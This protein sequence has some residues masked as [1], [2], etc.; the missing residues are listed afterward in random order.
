MC[1]SICSKLIWGDKMKERKINTWPLITILL[2]L[3]LLIIDIFIIFIID[4]NIFPYSNKIAMLD[5]LLTTSLLII[6]PNIYLVFFNIKKKIF[7][8]IYFAII[9]AWVEYSFSLMA[10][11]FIIPL[12]IEL[13]Y[14]ITLNSSEK[15]T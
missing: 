9:F 2:S 7:F 6:I 14:V 11:L 1:N 15:S 13:I 12:I 10:F 5:L 4:M 3:I 8:Y